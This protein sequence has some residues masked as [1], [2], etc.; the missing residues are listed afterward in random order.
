MKEELMPR[1]STGHRE[2][3][4]D[5]QLELMIGP[6]RIPGE[7]GTVSGFESD[8]DRHQAWLA[9]EDEIR[10]ACGGE[11]WAAKHYR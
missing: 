1:S 3:T 10:E 5:Q 2:L 4:L 11:P 7:T 6:G 9:H 8:E